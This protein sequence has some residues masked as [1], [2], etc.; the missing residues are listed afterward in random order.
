[1]REFSYFKHV[2]YKLRVLTWAVFADA[3]TEKICA[4]VNT[5]WSG[6]KENSVVETVEENYLVRDLE[7]RYNGVRIFCTGDFNMHGN[8]A[9]EP[10]KE[11]TGLIDAR[12]AAEEA[13]TLINKLTGIGGNIYID[14]VFLNRHMK[15]TRY[16]TVD[17][18]PAHILSDH[19][20][21]YGDFK[22]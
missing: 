7:T 2:K 19:L 17:N 12:E 20:P 8:F 13:G 6:N 18:H 22:L 10:F 21:Q 11:A 3:K 14:H 16:E 5:H 15:V 1:M 4:L 9:F